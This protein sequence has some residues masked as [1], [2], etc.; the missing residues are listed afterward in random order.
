MLRLFFIF[1]II[2]AY[3]ISNLGKIKMPYNHTLKSNTLNFVSK[4]GSRNRLR[5]PVAGT[6]NCNIQPGDRVEVFFDFRNMQVSCIKHADGNYKVERD[7]AVR[8]P[9]HKF[10][11]SADDVYTAC[12]KINKTVVL[13]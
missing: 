13:V 12:D 6:R 3:Y 5:I 8:F 1:Q 7:G 10:G 11:L 4:T 9:A 2:Q